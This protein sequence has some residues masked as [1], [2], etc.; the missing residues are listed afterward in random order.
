VE[1]QPLSGVLAD[2]HLFESDSVAPEW[3]RR[4][5]EELM[6]SRPSF[7][8][9]GLGQYNSRLAIESYVDLRPWLADYERV[10]GTEFTVIYRRQ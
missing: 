6:R 7:I 10:E 1:S 3:A 4:N 8:V 5:R 2:R 9:D